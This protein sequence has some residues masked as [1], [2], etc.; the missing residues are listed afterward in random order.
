MKKEEG[1]ERRG[2]TGRIF[3]KEKL[4]NQKHE[5]KELTPDF[6]TEPLKKDS[7]S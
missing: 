5:K 2:G 6:F 3:S 4:K 1:T 7:T